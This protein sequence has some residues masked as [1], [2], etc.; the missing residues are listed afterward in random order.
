VLIGIGN[1]SNRVGFFCD[2]AAGFDGAV[3]LEQLSLHFTHAASPYARE[4]TEIQ[5]LD[6]L[7]EMLETR[8]R[9]AR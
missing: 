8:G 3:C 5:S 2:E 9:R 4:R 1:V 7:E 6:L